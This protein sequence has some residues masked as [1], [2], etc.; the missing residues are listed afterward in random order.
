[1]RIINNDANAVIKW[2]LTDVCQFKC[3]YCI[4]R[5]FITKAN[6]KED[7]E[8]CFKSIDEVIRIANDLNKVTN[9]KVKVDLIGGEVTILPSL[10]IIIDRL[11]KED[12]IEK[13]NIT[14]NFESDKIPSGDK[15][16]FTAS[17]HPTQTKMSIEE[18]FKKASDYKEKF[19]Y[20]KVETVA[21][22]DAKHIDEFVK[23][24]I[25]NNIPYQVEEDLTNPNCKGKACSSN[26]KVARYT[27]IDDEGKERKFVTRNEFLKKYGKNGISMFTGNKLCSRDFDYV[28]I[29][30]DEVCLCA[31]PNI[32]LK[33]Y[34][35]V[36]GFHP[37]WRGPE[38][39]CTLC[40]NISIKTIPELVF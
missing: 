14:S 6:L 25:A 18:W 39:H 38:G 13:V 5:D 3:P 33:D 1:M 26:K 8:K 28:Y 35:V 32:K 34:K 17:Y 23:L 24:A 20:F 10:N 12:V 15:I 27:V 7:D 11:V 40:G 9:K 30:Q 21:T 2:R 4:R 22:E 16:S 19:K 29:E 36:S 31:M 37:C